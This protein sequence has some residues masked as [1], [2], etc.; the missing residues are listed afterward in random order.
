MKIEDNELLQKIKHLS[1]HGKSLQLSCALI[2]ELVP[3]TSFF[4]LYRID[5]VGELSATLL[6]HKGGTILRFIVT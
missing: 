4:I 3:F 2:M 1:K 6:T 5:I